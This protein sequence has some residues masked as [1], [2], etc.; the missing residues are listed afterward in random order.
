MRA[1]IL[2]AGEGTRMRPLTYS[3]AKHLIPIANKPVID[4]IL[5]A[6]KD[7]GIREIGIVVS[8]GTKASFKSYLQDGSRY[9]LDLSYIVQQKPKGLAHA[10]QCA[11]GFVGSESFLLYL[12]DNLLEN[13]VRG[14]V[15]QFRQGDSHAVISLVEVDNPRSFGVAWLKNGEIK[16]VVEKPDDPSTNLAVIG[17]YVFDYH[18][19]AAIEKIS[20]SKRGELEITDAIQQLIDDGYRVVPHR[21]TGWWKDVGTPMDMIDANQLLLDAMI[22]ETRMKSGISLEVKGKIAQNENA[23]VRD[24]KLIGPVIMGENVVIEGSVIGPYV[25][26]GNGVIIKNSKIEN[27]IILEQAVITDAKSIDR[28]LIGRYAELRVMGD[29]SS[30]FLLGD[31]SQVLKGSSEC[32]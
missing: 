15:K 23:R 28:S 3:K 6:I 32:W 19:F 13:G 14:L 10:V 29:S 4:L 17:T 1:V 16:K 18:I 27:S 22:P 2:C 26:I 11:Q 30:R 20:P 12:G 31:H 8:P 5:Q 7:A 24:S 21:V 25:S 9:D